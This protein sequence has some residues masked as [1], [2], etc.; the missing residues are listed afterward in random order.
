M[1]GRQGRTPQEARR[2]FRGNWYAGERVLRW[3]FAAHG[4][5]RD[6]FAR[7]VLGC[8]DGRHLTAWYTRKRFI[9]RKAVHRM[10]KYLQTAEVLG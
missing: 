8:V 4:G 10:R 2:S 3:A 7:D 5:S 6:A 1:N 9:P